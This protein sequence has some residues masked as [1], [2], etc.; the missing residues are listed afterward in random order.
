[1]PAQ[2]LYELRLSAFDFPATLPNNNANFRF[3]FDVRYMKADGSFASEHVVLPG[4][5]AFWECDNTKHAAANFV[6][7]DAEPSF[8]MTRVDAWESTVLIFRAV[9]VHSVNV[10]VLDVDRRDAFDVI[11][12][13]L[14]TLVEAAIGKAKSALPSFGGQL[15]QFRDTLGEAADEIQ[16]YALKKLAGGAKTKLLFKRSGL[17]S[18]P[19]P[20]ATEFVQ[21]ISGKGF[22]GDEQLGD[23]R[24]EVTLTLLEAAGAAV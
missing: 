8:D 16:S 2:A 5:D 24:V 20:P 10:S 14:G 15:A 12:E 19:A 21:T 9:R 4:L 18:L 13:Q 6:R 11:Q 22:A 17:L 7:A 1:M 3:V 23:Y